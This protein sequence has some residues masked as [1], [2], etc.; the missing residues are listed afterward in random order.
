MTDAI[1]VTGGAG[2]LGSALVK[3]LT[4]NGANVLA[5]ARGE[6]DLSDLD[7]VS[8][9]MCNNSVGAVVHLAACLDRRELP[10]A[11]ELQW[12]DTFGVGRSVL[13]AAARAGV[14]LVI[15]AGS[16]DEVGL[17]DGIVD[18]EVDPSPMTVYGLCKSLLLQTARFLSARHNMQIEWF[19]PTTMYGPGQGSG[20]MLVPT[21]F[22]SGMAQEPA[23]F[24]SGIQRRDFVYIDDIVDWV[25]RALRIEGRRAGVTVHHV[26]SGEA[27]SVADVLRKIEKLTDGDFALGVIPRRPG[28]PELFGVPP[29]SDQRS[30]LDDWKPR[31]GLDDGLTRTLTWWT[32]RQ[33]KH[34]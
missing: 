27:V 6:L 17:I 31:V 4:E 22:A 10:E 14:S 29:Y 26:G 9:Y 8:D 12:R 1:F 18:S 20:P 23:Q 33:A 25:V 7:A 24:T 15:A 16:M 19:R 28:E 34:S 3:Q 2:F 21:A 11:E 32:E 5:P 30:P 13:T